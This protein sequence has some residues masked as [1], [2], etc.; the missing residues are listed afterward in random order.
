MIEAACNEMSTQEALDQFVSH[1]LA[2]TN[3]MWAAANFDDV[4]MSEDIGLV[5]NNLHYEAFYLRRR[6][7]REID[8]RLEE[9][10]KQHPERLEEEG[11]Q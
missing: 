9:F 7:D 6:L 10:E 5:A 3:V 1:V 8:E 4:N 2:T 11:D